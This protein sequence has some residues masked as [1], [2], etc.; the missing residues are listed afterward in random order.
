MHVDIFSQFFEKIF[1]IIYLN[2]LKIM[3]F[4]QFSGF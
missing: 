2:L 3:K 4:T 1:F